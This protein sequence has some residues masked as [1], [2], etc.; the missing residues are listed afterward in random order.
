MKI[1]PRIQDQL[2]SF[3]NRL[4][5]FLDGEIAIPEK[6]A[7]EITERVMAVLY[8]ELEALPEEE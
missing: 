3:S 5:D 1:T 7:A 6:Q 8:S 2:E 4:Y